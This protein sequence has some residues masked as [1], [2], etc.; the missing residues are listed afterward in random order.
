MKTPEKTNK[1]D[2]IISAV[3]VQHKKLWNEQKSTE[4][5]IWSN[6]ITFERHVYMHSKSD[7]EKITENN[8]KYI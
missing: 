3:V 6:N 1:A 4:T 2:V 5:E 7:Y 8:E